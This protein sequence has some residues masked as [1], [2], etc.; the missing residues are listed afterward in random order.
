MISPYLHD[1][2]PVSLLIFSPLETVDFFMLFNLSGDGYSL[3]FRKK[4]PPRHK[5]FVSNLCIPKTGPHIWLQQNRQS[6]LEIY[7][8]LADI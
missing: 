4:Q 2:W 7:K 3:L 8:S 1:F 5:V 6:D